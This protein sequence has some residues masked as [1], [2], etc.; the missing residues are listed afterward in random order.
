MFGTA[1]EGSTELRC[2]AAEHVEGDR[3]PVGHRVADGRFGDKCLRKPIGGPKRYLPFLRTIRASAASTSPPPFRNEV[4]ASFL[5]VGV[6]SKGEEILLRLT[7]M[8]PT[9]TSLPRL[10]P[11]S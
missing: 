2:L 10:L 11:Q 5:L 9:D 4:Q 3:L 6:T 7:G 1:G 8:I